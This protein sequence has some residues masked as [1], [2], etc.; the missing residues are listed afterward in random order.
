MIA[1]SL[2]S[3][4]KYQDIVK[5]NS[6]KLNLQI[7]QEM[8]FRYLVEIV[9]KWPPED[10][11]R[12]FKRLFIDCLD[13][14]SSDIIPAI[15]GIS[16][17]NDEHEFRNTIKRCCYILVN[18]WASKRKH[19]YIQELINLFAEYSNIEL[20]YPPDLNLYKCWLQKFVISN[21]YEELK[22]FAYKY[23]DTKKVHWSNRYSAYLL[24]AQSFDV[25]N[26]QEQQEAA[27]NLSKQM[28]DTFKFELAM[29]IA[30]SQS[31]ASNV[32][33]YSNPSILGDDVL[34]LIKIIVVKKGI[35]SYEN[36]ANIFLKQTQNQTLKEFKES[37]QKYLFYS[38][39]QEL[40]K[41]FRHNLTDKLSSWNID[42]DEELINKHLLLRSCNR[43]VDC[44][45]TENGREPSLLF[46]ALL[47]QGHPLTLVIILLKIILICQ[48]SRS[49]LE[50]R[51]ANLISYYE[52]Y[53]EDECQWLINFIE[54][55]NITFAI[56]AE[57]IEYNLIKMK[58]NDKN[59]DSQLNLDTYRVFSQIRENTQ[60]L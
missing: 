2:P 47:S 12:E 1:K 35:F 57:N 32:S 53:S 39:N 40:V 41:V 26:P 13:F 22:L 43:I 19:K 33:R 20:N 36:L 7:R 44:L 56:Y 4:Q 24:V 11:L 29:Y 18:N 55:F 14:G 45:T 17:I 31:A 25:N 37:I 23:D 27:A 59:Y 48:N 6:Q 51:I 21:D 16:F 9:N 60:K 5:P 42:H 28:K 50:I 15:H 8:I 58:E 54:F 3:S 10:V 49:H 34:R 52:A 46:V 30:R 38:I